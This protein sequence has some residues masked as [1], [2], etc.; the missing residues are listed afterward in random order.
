M[1]QNHPGHGQDHRQPE[2][3]IGP[4]A[5]HEQTEQRDKYHLGRQGRRGHGHIAALQRTEGPDLPEKKEHPRSEGP[6]GSAGI[7]SGWTGQKQRGKKEAKNEVTEKQDRPGGD[8]TPEGDFQAERSS[9]VE[10]GRGQG[11]K[12]VGMQVVGNL[13]DSTSRGQPG[14]V[15]ACAF[16]LPGRWALL[17]SFL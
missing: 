4:V 1:E 10:H 7:P 16:R 6:D 12:E 11:Q 14:R 3:G 5:G 17:R 8:A 13:D 9:G 15:G 2:V